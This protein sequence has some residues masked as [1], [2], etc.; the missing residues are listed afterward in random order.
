MPKNFLAGSTSKRN[1][2]QEEYLIKF[3]KDLKEKNNLEGYEICTLVEH[4]VRI[5]LTYKSTGERLF[6]SSV[7]RCTHPQIGSSSRVLGGVFSADG[8]DLDRYDDVLSY[9]GRGV[10]WKFKG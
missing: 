8:A 6:I 10:R 4:M 3:N 5:F 7:A 1:A 9:V 2:E